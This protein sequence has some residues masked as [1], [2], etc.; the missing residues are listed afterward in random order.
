MIMKYGLQYIPPLWVAPMAVL[1]LGER[2]SLAKGA[3]PD[4]FARKAC[5][6]PPSASYLASKLN[7]MD[8]AR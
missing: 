3:G 5:Q 1:A 4:E 2:I 8:N 7:V 6:I